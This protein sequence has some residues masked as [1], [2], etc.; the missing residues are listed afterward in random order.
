MGTL[1]LHLYIREDI[2]L[3]VLSEGKYQLGLRS[4]GLRNADLRSDVA[5][6]EGVLFPSSATIRE[7]FRPFLKKASIYLSINGPLMP[8]YG[9]VLSTE[10]FVFSRLLLGPLTLNKQI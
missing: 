1:F 10:C 4:R 7:G 3:F 2:P 9:S 8:S 5:I 6:I